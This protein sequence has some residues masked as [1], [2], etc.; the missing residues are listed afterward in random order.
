MPIRILY[1][2]SGSGKTY[3][4]YKRIIDESICNEQGRY[5]FIV[6]E[7]SSLQAQKKVVRMH[8]N[9]GVF[10]IDILTFGRLCYRVFEE[11]SV[12]L[13][14]TIDDTGKNLI[15]RKVVSDMENEFRIVRPGKRQ[16]FINELKSLISELKQY[17]IKPGD[18]QLLQENIKNDRLN[19]KI[20][21]IRKV[22]E[23]FEQYIEGR[24][25]TIEDKPELLYNVLDRSVLFDDAVVVFDGFTGF[26]PIQYRIIEKITSKAKDVVVTA[27]IS[28]DTDYNVSY[29]VEE[30]FHMSKHMIKKFG[31]IA[32]ALHTDISVHRMIADDGNYRFKNSMELDFVEKNIFRYNG[33]K[34]KGS[35]RNINITKH[36][37]YTDEIRF[38]AA[39]ILE[40]IQENGFRYKDIGVVTGDSKIYADE[41]KRI[42]CESGIPVFMD[43]KR[44]LFGNPLVEY[45]R[46]V[47]EVIIKDFSYESV[48]RVL[49]NGLC[50]IDRD[51]ISLFE[52]YILAFGIRGHKR[53]E[54]KFVR[55]YKGKNIDLDTINRVRVQF[56]ELIDSFRNCII[57]RKNTAKEYVNAVYTF[58][59]NQN[60][61][62][63]MEKMAEI[64]EDESRAEE[65][66]KC[67]GH[68]VTLLD[69]IY[70][71]LGDEEL[72]H[73][74]FSEIL[75]AG[76][77]EIKVGLIPISGDC[78]MVGDL[79]RTRFDDIKVL[80]V[81]G[82]NEGIIPKETG[83]AG[84][85]SEE[86]RKMLADNDIVLSPSATEQVFIRNFYLYMNL[87]KPSDRLFITYHCYDSDGKETKC[88]R[89]VKLFENMF[90]G[91]HDENGRGCAI[92]D[93]ITNKSN[94]VHMITD[95]SGEMVADEGFKA[96]KEY[97]LEDENYRRMFDKNLEMTG[98]L[99]GDN[100][101]SKTA[102][103][104]LYQD[105]V[106]SSISRIET[107]ADC[108]FR[109]FAE[110]GLNLCERRE[111]ELN[112]MDIGSV[113]HMVLERMGIELLQNNMNFSDLDD[114]KRHELTIKY[115]DKVTLD[116]KDSFF[117]ENNTNAYMKKRL[118]DMIER[119]VM[120]L[121]VQLKAGDFVPW[122]FEKKF[123]NVYKD[124]VI[125]GKVDR[126]D[127]VTK[128]DGTYVKIIDYKS[129]EKSISREDILSGRNIQMMVYMKNIIDELEKK[130]GR[131]VTPSAAL[132]NRIFDPIVDG[133][134]E[135]SLIK[136]YRPSGI[137]EHESI[138]M[139]DKN[140]EGES[141]VI[142]A[143]ETKGIVKLDDK[144]VT[145]EQF[146]QMAQYSVNKMVS[147]ADEIYSGKT[148]ANPYEDSCKYCKYNCVCGF[149]LVDV[150]PFRK[151]SKE[152]KEE[153]FKIIGEEVNVDGTDERTADGN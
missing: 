37:S 46:G 76:F 132:Y 98:R 147:M 62:D 11:L 26:T 99:F 56:V 47:L 20:G 140:F 104:S 43:N 133:G 21:D 150:K 33:K 129:S 110:Y 53:Y 61:Y 73:I 17:G 9:H 89:I 48:F 30:L 39:K 94:S 119:T 36:S 81:L 72:S 59:E 69:R 118:A 18:L 109:H 65:F 90:P 97:L 19:E 42:F 113:F 14:E 12:N 137:L 29:G 78:V 41:I 120:A 148:E 85:L 139:L 123:S 87:T 91:I 146:M 153:F 142:P 102:A 100:N 25:V 15:I 70:G 16:G 108:A 74:E 60:V 22:Y 77:E 66:R 88:S 1:G 124:T 23:R 106:K 55:D 31:E 128:E 4:L 75:D 34:Y 71:L 93:Y 24:Y 151:I 79:E 122:V 8:P 143:K 38:C 7:Q 51:E 57:S 50:D 45:I 145:K 152:T 84:L 126:I 117:N 32:D 131:T 5:I 68:I 10:N 63:K 44:S 144:I 141:L 112:D 28:D 83:N 111:Y 138:G 58:M 101:I 96:L 107:F 92:T 40:Q 80:F 121:G 2:S 82:V 135:D 115:I 27:T 127:L 49:K 103:D 130:T 86:D 13:N 35:A 54:E 105:Y 52:N 114:T 6:P 136:A 95:T 64:V 125:E 67:Y 149:N 134:D 116:F 3:T